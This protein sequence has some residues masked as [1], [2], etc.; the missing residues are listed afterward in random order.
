MKS[1]FSI[2]NSLFSH[3]LSLALDSECWKPAEV[4]SDVQN[5]IEHIVNKGLGTPKSYDSKNKNH[6]DFIQLNNEKF[7]IFG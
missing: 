1:F 6:N 2:I 4:S 7:V 3:I 5:L